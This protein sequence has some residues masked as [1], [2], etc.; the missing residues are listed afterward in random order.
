MGTVF[1]CETVSMHA[2]TCVRVRVIWFDFARAIVS[3]R[4]C[5]RVFVCVCVCGRGEREGGKEGG[6]RGKREGGRERWKEGGGKERVREGGH[7]AA[8]AAESWV[9]G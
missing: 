1:L 3:C 4:F 8:C 9:W 2:C 7:V 5:L 6:G